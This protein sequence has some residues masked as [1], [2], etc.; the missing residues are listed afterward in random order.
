MILDEE[1]PEGTDSSRLDGLRKNINDKDYVCAA[2]H[3]I[4]IVLSEGLMDMA[5]KRGYGNDG[6]RKGGGT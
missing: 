2:I 1:E 6:K 3:R 4:A 5:R